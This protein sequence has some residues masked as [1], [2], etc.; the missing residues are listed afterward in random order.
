MTA[1]TS[2]SLLYARRQ[3]VTLFS[4][5][6]SRRVEPAVVATGRGRPAGA[7]EHAGKSVIGSPPD[8]EMTFMDFA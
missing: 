3:G 8:Y 5:A 2:R 6:G 4:G 7:A 1:G